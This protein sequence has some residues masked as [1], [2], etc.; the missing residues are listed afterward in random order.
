MPSL[1]NLGVNLDDPEKRQGGAYGFN[2]KG[3]ERL[4]LAPDLT[5]NSFVVAL[6]QIMKT[7]LK[8][9]SGRKVVPTTLLSHR[10]ECFKL[11]NLF[12]IMSWCT[13]ESDPGVFTE[14]IQQMQVKGV[15]ISSQHKEHINIKD[16]CKQFQ[17]SRYYHNSSRFFYVAFI[18]WL[19]PIP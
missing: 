11:A 1:R 12:A 13:T 15:Q 8:M 16:L 2:I 5:T 9:P 6:H 3:A 17:T 19:L 4:K 7:G 18:C 14:L 10:A